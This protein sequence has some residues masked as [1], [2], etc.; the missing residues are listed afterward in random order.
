M[1]LAQTPYCSAVKA[2]DSRSRAK[3]AI[4]TEIIAPYRI[5]VFNALAKRKELD[6]HV[7]F[8]AETDP[9][10]R[11]WRV[12]KE[13]IEFRYD[14]LPSWRRR[15]R[16]HHLLLNRGVVKAL[17]RIRPDVLICGGYNY[18]ASWQ[19]VLWARS[20]RVPALLWSESTAHEQRSRHRLIEF[21]KILFLRLCQGF[22]V[23]GTASEEYLRALGIAR[24]C[25]FRAPNAVDID[26]FSTLAQDCHQQLELRALLDVP[27][28]YFLYVGRLVKEKGL[29]DLLRAYARLDPCLRS[30]VGLVLSGHGQD[31]VALMEEASRIKPGAIRF[32][33]FLHREDLP[34]LY[35]LADAVVL[36]THSDP[37]GL[38][39]NEAMSCGRP[40]VVTSVAG[41][42][43]D[44]VKDGWNGHVVSPANISQLSSSLARLAENSELRRQMGIRGWEM[45]QAFSPDSWA[46]GIANALSAMRRRTH[47]PTA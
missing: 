38:V 35:A 7:I 13:E 45:I 20:H 37:W 34:S 29:F 33:G 44:L 9:T 36:P 6:L 10:W 28:R 27:S 32:V 17:N 19:A 3:L 2:E 5:P 12:Y 40:V 39:V 21:L 16:K 8:L 41:C 1:A 47:E 14:V 31:Q 24:D 46:Y 23:P 15:F 18:V 30:K 26:F 25:I 11:Q 42:A 4:V 22:V 43:S